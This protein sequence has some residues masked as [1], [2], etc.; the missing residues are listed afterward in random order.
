MKR[1]LWAFL[2]LFFHPL[3]AEDEKTINVDSILETH[4]N[5]ALKFTTQSEEEALFIRRIAD[6]WQEGEYEI[7]KSQ[8]EE[9]LKDYPDSLFA[10]SLSA[11]LGDLYVR[12]KNY[13]G[14]LLQYARIKNPEISND[15][16]FNRMQC[17]YD[18]QWYST[19]ADECE[20][21]LK[22]PLNDDSTFKATYL[23]AAALYQQCI[24][25]EK[26][27][28][29]M[30]AIAKRAKP[31]F[32]RL[33]NSKFS[34]EIVA[35]Y[36][37]LCRILKEYS[38]ASDLYLKLAQKDTEN[39]EE[40]LF[41][42]A[43]LQAEFDPASAIQTLNEI[44]SKG[45]QRAEDAIYQRLMISYDAG[46]YEEVLKKKDEILSQMPQE[47]QNVLHLFFGR[48]HLQIKE[49]G[50][51][52]KEL[53]LFTSQANS[54]DMTRSALGDLVTAAYYLSDEESLIEAA[55]K[56]GD[57]FPNDPE[58]SKATLT[59]ALL[60]KKT[61]RFEEAIEKLKNLPLS[62][63][64]FEQ[65]GCEFEIKRWSD[66]HQHCHEYL[67]K[68]ST[69][70]PVYVWR[71][72]VT[73]AQHL[74]SAD[75]SFKE[76][77]VKDLNQL[78]HQELLPNEEKQDW[79]LLLAQT[80][81]DLKN[82]S[83]AILSL[84]SLIQESTTKKANARLLLAFCYREIGEMKL[85]CSLAEEALIAHADLINESAIHIALFNGYL[86]YPEPLIEKAA[87]HLFSASQ[88]TELQP[89]NLLWLADNYY[90]K[91]KIKDPLRSTW[92]QRSFVLLE[93]FISLKKIDF[94]SLDE[95]TIQYEDALIK[96]AE[97]RGLLGQRQQEL[98]MLESLKKQHTDHPLWPAM[99]ES[100]V[101][102]LLAEQNV[103]LGKID[104]AMNL[105]D[106]ILSKYPTLNS[107][108]SASASLQSARLKLATL[109]QKKLPVDHPDCVRL[110]TQLKTLVLQKTLVNEPIHLEGALEYIDFQASEGMAK[111]LSLLTKTRT[112]FEST[113]DLL[114]LDYQ[115]SRKNLPD[116]DRIYRAYISLIDAEI[117]SCQALLCQNAS[118][119]KDLLEK[120]KKSLE[121]I[122]NHPLTDFLATKS[123]EQLERLKNANPE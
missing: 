28:E 11:T 72:L 82:Y 67:E 48:S 3:F 64:L 43:R 65:I 93:K 69:S 114:S 120:A 76:E 24:N 44:A 107:F 15:I 30:Q 113:S 50:E 99:E 83:E 20:N 68:N 36:A 56:L 79:V 39:S 115:N 89:D 81:Y 77:L 112:D 8:I 91:T 7:V 103:Q 16:F 84:E 74:A 104:K 42:A 59:H 57:L 12:E 31:Y 62:A 37:H 10:E 73:A 41:Q 94:Q 105:F 71:Y 95:S 78:L 21:Y 14:A 100:K 22:T 17:L 49:Y 122:Q 6:F 88:T 4:A 5:H 80:N 111:R 63:A 26:D 38:S 117:M 46:R 110:L 102:L 98:S 27:S 45:G 13:Q 34:Q 35:P 75:V 123:Q 53:K 55:Q 29:K 92:I 119:R 19:I 87:D 97:L 25:T 18:L 51:A 60:L 1:L 52:L 9:F 23:L 32:E 116:Q 61:N 106:R 90:R 109:M 118:E 86:A 58:I 121:E 54:S 108:V 47:R 40:M 96:M 85:F 2:T 66:C 33:L 70:D 101:D